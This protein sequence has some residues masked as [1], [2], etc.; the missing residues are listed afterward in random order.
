MEMSSDLTTDIAAGL[1][2]RKSA[3]AAGL[4]YLLFALSISFSMVYVD[5]KFFIPGDAMA[6]VARILASERLFRLGFVSGLVGEIFFLLLAHSLYGLFRPVDRNQ[7]RLLVIFM[8]ASVPVAYLDM[9]NRFVPVLL[10]GGEVYRSAF[11]QNQLNALAMLFLDIHKHGYFISDTFWGLWL[12]PLGFLVFKS[13]S[14]LI[15]RV[16]GVLLMAGCFCYLLHFLAIFLFPSYIGI[17]HSGIDTI[18][19]GGEITSILWL[20]IKGFRPRSRVARGIA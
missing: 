18:A 9:L 15:S 12:F 11:E 19:T 16:P 10:L 6:T 1:A 3:R 4:W 13:S 8:V 7:A 17:T 5:P 20:L 14:N 2:Q